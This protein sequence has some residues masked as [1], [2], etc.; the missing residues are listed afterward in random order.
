LVDGV[1]NGGRSGCAGTCIR[2]PRLQYQDRFKARDRA[3][4]RHEFT[5]VRDAFDI[6]QDRSR[7]LIRSE[8]IEHIAKIDIRH[9]A[10]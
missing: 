6:Q 5:T 1:G 7:M 4:R 8:I 10:Q 3:G 2:A 9:F